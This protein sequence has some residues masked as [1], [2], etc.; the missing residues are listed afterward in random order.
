MNISNKCSFITI[1]IFTIL[2]IK[3]SYA[4]VGKISKNQRLL[5]R[6]KKRCINKNNNRKLKR[7]CEK[8]HSLD[9]LDENNTSVN[10]KISDN[11]ISYNKIFS[12]N[13]D[14]SIVFLSNYTK[15]NYKEIKNLMVFGDSHSAIGTNYTDMSYSGWNQARGKNWPLYLKEFNKN[16]T[17]W[18]YAKGGSLIDENLVKIPSYY[19]IDLKKQYEYF[20]E[21]MSEGKQ[22]EKIWNKNNSLFAF[23]IGNI[24][25]H[26][27]YRK[28][29]TIEI[30]KITNKLFESINKMYD[31]GARNIL[32][33][34]IFNKGCILNKNHFLKNDVLEFNNNVLKRSEDFFKK[35]SDSNFIIYKAN[36]KL[37]NIYSN[38]KEY[39]FEDCTNMWEKNK[40]KNISI[41]LWVNS[42]LT[43]RGNKI[44]AED[45]N[46]LLNSINN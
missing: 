38:C 7:F 30:D 22:F 28:N 45:I 25:I 42:H 14:S 43:D 40:E 33:L 23:W 15:F 17:L 5:L 11:K 12:E 16:I 2:F 13:N 31:V 37:A 39:K 20:Y 36:N 21:N 44:L 24:D 9:I 19:K 3:L 35:H 34:N 27:L 10:D 1:L 6:C 8:C 29:V 32:I 46:N 18:N 41:Y 4:F 26:Q